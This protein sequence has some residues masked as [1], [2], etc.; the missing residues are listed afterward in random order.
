ME[1]E[2][3]HEWK[4]NTDVYP[5]DGKERCI[6]CGELRDYDYDGDDGRDFTAP[7]EP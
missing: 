2:C 5:G 4:P 6:H 1:H 7:Y 3:E